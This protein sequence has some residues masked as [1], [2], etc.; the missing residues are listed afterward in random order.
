MIQLVILIHSVAC[1]TSIFS[2]F[3]RARAG[4]DNNLD[5][6][7]LP[8]GLKP[9]GGLPER[10]SHCAT[11]NDE[12]VAGFWNTEACGSYVWWPMSSTMSKM[13]IKLLRK[14]LL[15]FAEEAQRCAR[16]GVHLS[17]A[18]HTLGKVSVKSPR[19]LEN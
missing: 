8:A 2:S 6:N 10:A 7:S 14:I 15:R 18:K 9:G 16:I 3:A 17:H 1:N 13:L 11:V 19:E 4:F 12:T 5:F